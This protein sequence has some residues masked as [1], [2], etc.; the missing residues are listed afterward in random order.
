MRKSTRSE[1][2]DSNVLLFAKIHKALQ[3]E[4]QAVQEVV[5]QM[6]DIINDPKAEQDEIDSAVLTVVEAL[7]HES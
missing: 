2:F 3:E 4:S 6:L 7:F 1:I 5:Y